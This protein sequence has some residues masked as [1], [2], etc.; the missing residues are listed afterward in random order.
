MRGVLHPKYDH[1]AALVVV[2]AAAAV[3]LAVAVAA[4]SGAQPSPNTNSLFAHASAPFQVPL[5]ILAKE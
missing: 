3:A 1:S 4:A 2:E 5:G